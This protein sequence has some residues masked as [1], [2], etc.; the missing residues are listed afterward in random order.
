MKTFLYRSI[1]GIFFGAFIA[2]IMTNSVV[3]FSGKEMLD[4]HLFLKNSL[5]SIFCGWFFTVTTTLF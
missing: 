1:I 4:G 5:G 2:V 3:L